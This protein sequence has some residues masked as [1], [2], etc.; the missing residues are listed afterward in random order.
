MRQLNLLFRK[1]IIGRVSEIM[2]WSRSI[3]FGVWAS[4]GARKRCRAFFKRAK[5]QLDSKLFGVFDYGLS[6]ISGRLMKGFTDRF[7]MP[8]SRYTMSCTNEMEAAGLMCLPM[9]L[10]AVLVWPMIQKWRFICVQSP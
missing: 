10:I 5:Y 2:D 9:V 4:A 1:W 3:V 7:P 6:H 8:I